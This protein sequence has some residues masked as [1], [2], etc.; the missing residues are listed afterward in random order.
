MTSVRRDTTTPLNVA[1]THRDGGSRS[2]AALVYMIY[3]LSSHLLAIQD[4]LHCGSTTSETRID[5]RGTS[6]ILLAVIDSQSSGHLDRL[7][8]RL[9]TS[10]R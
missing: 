7:G 2:T 3:S 8:T 9:N 10:C 6:A 1:N 5:H 4:H